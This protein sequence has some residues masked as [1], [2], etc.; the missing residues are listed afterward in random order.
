MSI[1]AY[2]EY[3][4]LAVKLLSTAA[5]LYRALLRC[6]F[7]AG[8]TLRFRSL[9]VS[10]I[11]LAAD[12]LKMSDGSVSTTFAHNVGPHP[13]PSLQCRP[14]PAH[15]P[16]HEPAWLLLICFPPSNLLLMCIQLSARFVVK[17]PVMQYCFINSN[18]TKLCTN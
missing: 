6:N 14:A 4:I 10:L 12:S 13:A 7:A 15:Q 5:V 18:F 17:L 3:A 11:A 9:S 1:D 8:L 16:S 2:L